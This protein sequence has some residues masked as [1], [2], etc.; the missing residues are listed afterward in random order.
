MAGRGKMTDP[1]LEVP[2]FPLIVTLVTMTSLE[3]GPFK[4]RVLTT[5]LLLV[6]TSP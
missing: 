6:K 4:R 5:A 3:V 1:S 2:T